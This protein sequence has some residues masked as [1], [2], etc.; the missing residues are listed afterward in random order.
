MKSDRQTIRQRIDAVFSL[1]LLGALPIDIR[2]HAADQGWNV[3]ERQLQRYT[4]AA[5]KLLGASLERNHDQL[6]AHHFAARR[7][8]YARA[9]SV[10]DYG[11]AL[12][13]LDSEAKLVGLFDMKLDDLAKQVRE[14]REWVEEVV[15]FQRGNKS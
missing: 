10:S 5:D 11:T 4:A 7:A 3:G 9:M 8:L 1:R 6:L 2:R 15:G 12:R 13:T 14:L